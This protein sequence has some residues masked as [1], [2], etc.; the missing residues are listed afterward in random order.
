MVGVYLLA[1]QSA[2]S[3]NDT[4]A[5]DANLGEYAEEQR[6]S[7]TVRAEVT[8]INAGGDVVMDSFG[9]QIYQGSVI[10]ND[11]DQIYTSEAG[12]VS[13]L[14]VT[15]T[16]QTSHT[17]QSSDFAWVTMK[18]EGSLD[19]TVR[20]VSLQPGG[21]V[22]INAAKDINVDLRQINAQTGPELVAALV[23][24]NPEMAWLQQL[25]DQ[26]DINWNEVQEVHE[27]WSDESETLG[28]GASA[29]IAIVVTVFTAGAG[30]GA[31]GALTTEAFAT[32]YVGT[33]SAIA[34]ASGA[35]ITS[36]AVS[37]TTGTIN[38][39]GR[40]D[41]SLSDLGQKD[42]LRGLG[43]SA[44]TAG[45]TVG[46]DKLFEN[47][48]WG[49][50]G[51]VKTDPTYSITKGFAL[52]GWQGKLGFAAHNATTGLASAAVNDAIY[53]GHFSDYLRS[54]MESQ[55]NNVLSA[56]A[57][58]QIGTLTTKFSASA[59]L[60]GHA[61]L[62]QAL[63]EGGSLR[64]VGHAIVGG[65]I[66]EIT[67]G[68]F[69][70]G[71]S[72]GAASA[73]VTPFLKDF[74]EAAEANLRGPADAWSNAGAELAGV[75]GA[76]LAGGDVS[77]GQWIANQGYNYNAKIHERGA[78]LLDAAR[79]KVSEMPISDA[80]KAQKVNRLVAL[81]CAAR[82][83]SSGVP[84]GDVLKR[85][86]QTLEQQGATLIAMGTTLE[87]ELNALGLSRQV[88]T[89]SGRRKQ[90]IG[91]TDVF[92]YSL[93]NTIED[94]ASRNTGV[95]L[96]LIGYGAERTYF[97]ASAGTVNGIAGV[98]N[99]LG[100]FSWSED[101][102]GFGDYMYEQMDASFAEEFGPRS[103]QSVVDSFSMRTYADSTTYSA[104]LGLLAAELIPI[105]KLFKSGDRLYDAVDDM[106]DMSRALDTTLFKDSVASDG[107]LYDMPWGKSD[108][109]GDG[110]G[111]S[112][113]SFDGNGFGRV[114]DVGATA[115][116]GVV[117]NSTS[118]V[119]DIATQSLKGKYARRTDVS[120][121]AGDDVNSTFPS[122]WEPPYKPGTRVTEFNSTVDDVYVRVHGE[123]NKAR[124][125]M[126][127]REALDGLT[128]QQ[129]QSKYALP[130][131]PTFMSEV[132]VPAGTQ[133]RT[134][135][136]NPVFDGVGNATQYELLQ[137]LPESVFQNT[138]R[139]G[140]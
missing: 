65:G 37:L 101:L 69:G 72:A 43:A 44:L 68:D 52:D 23:E 17:E 1:G 4:F 29:V 7:S 86:L 79:E 81:A 88:I 24:Q 107:Y 5:S 140:Q 109:F 89:R 99:G 3:H 105:G 31:A 58:N 94:A 39:G 102:Q 113:G 34:A 20:M 12:S 95:G 2:T 35:M 67:G 54:S 21:D 124:S 78:A 128:P 40:L 8:S 59:E 26:G 49:R 9:D 123:T 108:D 15:D 56:F 48:T 11:G 103:G 117:P 92:R 84:D 85:Q 45:L 33:T 119:D 74:G 132:H 46:V 96:D 104:E 80:E 6:S 70:T 62:A 19:Q 47:W 93:F 122:G 77:E 75:F 38:N 25:S 13:F 137:R 55:G 57:F 139:L 98:A 100:E 32:A 41:R 63:D 130:E 27:R 71:A 116:W 53:G 111:H 30:A 129:I 115:G 138:V 127:K 16:T 112:F 136:V 22:I 120:Y 90:L 18:S 73:L 135:T 51:M 118:V 61:G 83:C 133:I 64:V 10:T 82:N 121:R 66:S 134:G 126:M 114:D 91:S 42:S 97:A 110:Y 125:W 28:T 76:A 106:H 14:A 131:L 87:T 36:A 60:S 50:E